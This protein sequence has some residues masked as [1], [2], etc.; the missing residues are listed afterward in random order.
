MNPG[1]STAFNL[2]ASDAERWPA[3]KIQL[4]DVFALAHTDIL[5]KLS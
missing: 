3:D 5:E 2:F 1:I 4:A